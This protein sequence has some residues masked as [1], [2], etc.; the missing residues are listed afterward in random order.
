MS[1]V[2]RAFAV[3]GAL[4][5]LTAGGAGAAD[6]T[7]P[8]VLSGPGAFAAGYATPVVVVGAGGELE[9]TNFDVTLHDVIAVDEDEAGTPLFA[10]AKI[11]IGQTAGVVG[12]ELL[13]PGSY[14]F[15]CSLHEATMQGT[16]VVA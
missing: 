14:E 9:Y 2:G 11:G 12:V 7:T 16:L 8:R 15:Y 13:E 6:G 3:A 1:R 4:A 5:L 10:S